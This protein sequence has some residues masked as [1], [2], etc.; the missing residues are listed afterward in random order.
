MTTIVKWTDGTVCCD[1]EWEDAYRRF[2][3]PQAEVA[4]FIR[5]LEELG[6]DAVDRDARVV[7]LFCGRGN[8]LVA[9]SSLGFRNLQGVDL[10][11]ALAAVYDGDATLYVGDCRALQFA[12]GGI[13][14]VT[15][16]GG[17]HHLPVL[18][19]DLE[20]VLS[21]IARVLKPGG[22]LIVVEPWQTPFLGFVHWCCRQTLLRR[23]WPKL[24][25]LATMI[26]CEKTT[27][28]DWLSRPTAIRAAISLRFIVDFEQVGY[29]KIMLRLRKGKS[30]ATA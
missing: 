3:T 16:H 12:D 11:P 28:F 26:E 23:L 14:L 1:S 13:D 18:M 10:S 19:D 29:G 5:R 8:G 4:K 30:P 9:L 27:Y 24:D 6:V 25:A 20:A 15:I 17:L 22:L 7:D 21:E 2:E